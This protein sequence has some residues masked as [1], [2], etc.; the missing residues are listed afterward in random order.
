MHDI[1]KIIPLF[2]DVYSDVNSFVPYICNQQ[3]KK[4]IGIKSDRY[5]DFGTTYNS[6]PKLIRLIDCNA[7]YKNT[8]ISV[9][10][11]S[12]DATTRSNANTQYIQRIYLDIDCHNCPTDDLDATLNTIYQHIMTLISQNKIPMPTVFVYSGRG[13]YLLYDYDMPIDTF[14]D[15]NY[16]TIARHNRAYKHIIAQMQLLLNLIDTTCIADVDTAVTDPSRTCRVPGTYNTASQSY[17]RLLLFNPAVTYAPS[18]LYQRFGISLDCPT[19][20]L[21]YAAYLT[22]TSAKKITTTSSRSSSEIDIMQ[23]TPPDIYPTTPNLYRQNVAPYNL[24]CLDKLYEINEW[25]EGAHRERFLFIYY[26]VYKALYGAVAAYEKIVSL[27]DEMTEPLEIRTINWTACHS[28]TVI[29]TNDVHSDGVLL[30][31]PYK[32][33]S[34]LELDYDIA[35]ACGFFDGLKKKQAEA[36][37]RLEKQKRNDTIANWY[38]QYNFSPTEIAELLTRQNIKC[39][40]QTVSNVI[41]NLNLDHYANYNAYLTATR[42]QFVSAKMRDLFTAYQDITSTTS[43]D[44]NTIL[45]ILLNQSNNFLLLGEAGTGKSTLINTLIAKSDKRIAICSYTGIATIH[46]R[47]AR[48]IHSLFK[49]PIKDIYTDDDVC[50][51]K[52]LRSIDTLIIDEISMVRIDLF[53]VIIKSIQV[54]EIEYDHKIQLILS[55]DLSQLSPFVTA[56]IKPAYRLMYDNKKYFFESSLYPNLDFQ[57][58]LL[59]SV[60]RQQDPTFVDILRRVRFCETTVLDVLQTAF[61]QTEYYNGTYLCQH[62]NQVN[63]I[64]LAHAAKHLSTCKRKASFTTTHGAIT[65]APGM[66]IMTTRNHYQYKNGLLGTIVAIKAD[67]YIDVM[68]QNN[69]RVRIT[70]VKSANN[71]DVYILP[72]TLAYAITIHK[73]QGLTLTGHINILCDDDFFAPA[74]LYVAL[75]RATDMSHVHLLNYNLTQK[76]LSADRAYTNAVSYMV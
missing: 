66:P 47:T 62:K 32:I 68:L 38:L 30:Y 43:T 31:N 14:V 9:N 21:P 20:E 52:A 69:K 22:R 54:T 18:D 26:N 76:S 55:G 46:F 60:Y 63:D 29:S 16:A 48:T 4:C 5:I 24:R 50:V 2:A 58:I 73:C 71:P 19:A 65:L 53:E 28:D 56:D 15:D 44:Y 67:K 12:S 37:R 34:K 6:S 45:D 40:R 25:V 41:N 39:P 42:Y 59:T 51:C 8:Y 3:G 27:N 7:K 74:M 23:Y 61:D 1:K 64:N 75:S 33:P 70:Y 36:Q 13:F 10:T 57:K 49:L 11:L 35:D 72:V 17:A